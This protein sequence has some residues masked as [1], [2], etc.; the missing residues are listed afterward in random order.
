M[1]FCFT[2]VILNRLLKAGPCLDV[3]SNPS[4]ILVS[5]PK[6]LKKANSYFSVTI[7]PKLPNT[8]LL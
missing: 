6:L 4:L 7:E 8:L 1:D 3:L 5:L 2:K